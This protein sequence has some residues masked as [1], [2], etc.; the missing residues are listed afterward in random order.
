M[1]SKTAKIILFAVA[2]ILPTIAMAAVSSTGGS[3]ACSTS[4]LTG[5][6][7]C[8]VS[9]LNRVIPFIIALALLYFLWGVT[10]YIRDSGEKADMEKAVTIITHGIVALFVMVSV[11]GLVNV[12]RNTLPFNSNQPPVPQFSR[13]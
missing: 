8:G 6:I 2:W 12:L 11:W 13:T 5:L 9:L 1:K 3:D 4:S 10:L 7:D